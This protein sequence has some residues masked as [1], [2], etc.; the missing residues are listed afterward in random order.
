MLQ[1]ALGAEELLVV[2]AEKLDFF[3]G[4][5]RAVGQV[6]LGA[7]A[8]DR[9]G[10][11][12]VRVGLAIVGLNCGCGSDHRK[13]GKNLVVDWQV[14]RQELVRRLVVRTLDG[15]VLG[16][17]LHALQAETVTTGE[18]EGLLVVMVVRLEADATLEY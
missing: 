4:M 17:P 11:G 15:L 18:G 5:R 6:D 7:G 14:L 12:G 13:P 1:D 16:H 8:F 3:G 9:S 2:A 10:G